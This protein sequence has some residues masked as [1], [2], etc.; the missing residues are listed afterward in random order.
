MPIEKQVVLFSGMDSLIA[1][2]CVGRPRN[3]LHVKLNTA[4]AEKEWE[5]VL[6]LRRALL[7][8]RWEVNLQ[9]F[10]LPWGRFEKRPSAY[11][12]FR[13]AILCFIA[14]NL[15]FRDIVLTSQKGELSL[16]DRSP[17][18]MAMLSVMMTKEVGEKVKVW[19]PFDRMTKQQMVGWYLEESL[20]IQHLLIAPGCYSDTKETY[21]GQCSCCF[22]KAI[23]LEANGISVEKYMPNIWE[24]EGIPEYVEKMK[25][26]EYDPERAS[27][28]KA[29]LEKHNLW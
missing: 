27:E 6:M 9:V 25:S 20:P 14:S 3:V 18:F 12:P 8:E 26:G 4:Y 11:L 1:W 16:W 17:E 19:T 2:H 7:L 24:W 5:Q 28:T 29:V 13:N 23:A 15:G 21:C 10:D 22:R